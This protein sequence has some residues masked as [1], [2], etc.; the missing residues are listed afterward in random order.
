MS[1]DRL[2]LIES[3]Q[4][5]GLPG[6]VGAALVVLAAGYALFGLVPG[7]EERD[8]AAERAQ[9][10]EARLARVQS[11]AEA[12]PEPPGR[13]LA[14]FHQALPAQ[15]EATAAIDRIYAAALAEGLTLARGEYALQ[16]DPETQHARYQI[17]LPVRGS[18]PQMRRFLG[19]ALAAVPAVA[20]ED[21]EFQR[22][23]I[24]EPELEARV[25]MTLYLARR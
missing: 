8:L 4:R 3:V 17:L 25:R 16:I 9:R 20:L 23:E 12:L 15:L 19:A 11:G 2:T 7:L 1:I 10:A 18:S 14:N 22:K 21:V 5:L 13:Q 6:A 24:S